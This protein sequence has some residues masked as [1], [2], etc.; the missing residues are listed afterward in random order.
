MPNSI[1]AAG[2]VGSA[3]M[4]EFGVKASALSNKL[5]LTLAHY[6]QS[7]IDVS[8][9]DVLAL[10]QADVSA[11]KTH[12]WEAELKWVPSHK[13]FVSF[14]A[15]RQTTEF[16]PNRGAN[17]LVDARTLGFQDV[18][19]SEGNVIF[20]AEAFLYGGRSFIVVPPGMSDYV[21]K[22]GNPTTQIGISGQYQLDNGLGMTFSGNY[23][24]SVYSGRLRQVKLDSSQ[25]FNLG[26]FLERDRWL[27]KVDINNLLDERYFRPRTG[28]NLGETLVSSM[29]GRHGNMIIRYE[30]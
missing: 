25:V 1:I 26:F 5:F 23:F 4:E 28:D 27:F 18:K 29:P 8:E 17:I 16:T 6:E 22:Q 30:F 24:S 12:G 21:E 15:L 3:R 10:L 9:D 13:I 11:T 7:R 20:P 14:Y 2:H 19:D